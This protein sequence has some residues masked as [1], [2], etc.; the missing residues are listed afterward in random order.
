MIR[1]IQTQ[2]GVR[3]I[4]TER[5]NRFVNSRTGAREW[6]RQNIDSIRNNRTAGLRYQDLTTRERQSFSAQNRYRFNGQF[7]PNPF[8]VLQQFEPVT[9]GDR[10][11]Q[12]YFTRED[13]QRISTFTVPFQTRND[14]RTGEGLRIRGELMDIAAEVNNYM[15]AGYDFTV[16]T[17]EGNMMQGM[18]A[19]EYL[20]QWES[21]TIE[22]FRNRGAAEGRTLDRILINYN[23]NVNMT[24]NT[25]VIDLNEID[26]DTD[27]DAYF[28]TP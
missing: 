14:G 2:R 16:I 1:R 9:R 10:N 19:I 13:I 23:V 27:I 21:Q 17:P 12:N 8:N 3:Y 24:N 25:I 5:G 11:L 4:D 6:V 26:E 15:R 22:R 20:R 18:N 28:D 7:L